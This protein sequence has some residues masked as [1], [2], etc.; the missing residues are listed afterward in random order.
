MVESNTPTGGERM[1]GFITVN[2]LACPGYIQEPL[3]CE[4]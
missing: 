4:N 3:L 2:P 1:F